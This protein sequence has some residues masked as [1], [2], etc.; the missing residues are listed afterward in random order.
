M[1]VTASDLLAYGVP[2][3]LFGLVLIGISIFQSMQF[4]GEFFHGNWSTLMMVFLCAE[5][6]APALLLS[7][8]GLVVGIG[9]AVSQL[10]AKFR[11]YEV[12]GCLSFTVALYGFGF[13]WL[14]GSGASILHLGEDPIASALII[15]ILL[16]PVSIVLTLVT[17]VVG[18]AAITKALD[19]I[20]GE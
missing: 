7:V 6:I 5:A 3:S 13:W 20:P 18:N 12:L 8:F 16:L 1:D 11:I 17:N 14:L 2:I 10:D 9:F 15:Y 4:S 19:V